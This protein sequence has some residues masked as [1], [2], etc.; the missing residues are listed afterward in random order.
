MTS[1]NAEKMALRVSEA[2]S[3]GKIVNLGK[4]ARESGYSNSTSKRPSQMTRS[5]S[6]QGIMKPLAEQLKSE[7]DRLAS[8]L[9]S[10]NL[11]EEKYETMAKSLDIL[12]KNYQLIT[13][14]VTERKVLV[15]PSELINKNA[16][17]HSTESDS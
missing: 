6:Y 1:L 16:I 4:I 13:G 3:A 14:G 15:L 2:I 9:V 8:E 12:N 17:T 5:K 10:R 11:G 7:I